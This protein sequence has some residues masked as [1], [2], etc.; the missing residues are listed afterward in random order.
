MESVTLA[1]K[2]AAEQMIQPTP[3]MMHEV[4]VSSPVSPVAPGDEVTSSGLSL[5]HALYS[6]A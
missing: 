5:A 2:I 1:R 3:S 6:F 4:A